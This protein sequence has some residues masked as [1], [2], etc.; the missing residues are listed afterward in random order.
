MNIN[1]SFDFFANAQYFSKQFRR[2]TFFCL[3]RSKKLLNHP[4][5]SS[6]DAPSKRPTN[7]PISAANDNIV[8]STYS[9]VVL[10]SCLKYKTA[11]A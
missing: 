1:H 10:I 11:Q 4:P 9:L 6:K 8:Y 7:A 5:T 3:H 2:L